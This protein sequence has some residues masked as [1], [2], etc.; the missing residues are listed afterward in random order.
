M[1]QITNLREK[2]VTPTPASLPLFP[3]EMLL[4]MYKK[5]SP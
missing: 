5:E 2:S 4:Y 3:A 1:N